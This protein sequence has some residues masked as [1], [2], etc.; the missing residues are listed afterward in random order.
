M[1]GGSAGKGGK[2]EVS[3]TVRR[4]KGGGGNLLEIRQSIA[5]QTNELMR[6][7]HTNLLAGRVYDIAKETGD[8]TYVEILSEEKV[9]R[10]DE[11]DRTELLRPK[12][13]ILT[14]LHDGKKITM[15]LSK[16]LVLAFEGIEGNSFDSKNPL[17]RAPARAMN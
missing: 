13:G 17:L 6:F 15:K 14:F 1:G 9:E 5:E 2:L 3:S 10:S 12:E 16:E 11:V 8:T 7:G 4:A